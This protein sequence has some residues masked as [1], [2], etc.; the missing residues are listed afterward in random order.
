MF[1]TAVLLKK[2]IA[3]EGKLATKRSYAVKKVAIFPSPAWILLTKLSLA[4]NNYS[5]PGRVCFVTSRL[6]TVKSLTFFYN[7]TILPFFCHFSSAWQG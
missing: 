4:G 6:G 7:V 1:P 2:T 5:L 3:T